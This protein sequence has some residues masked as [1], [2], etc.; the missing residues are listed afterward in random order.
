[1]AVFWPWLLHL[2]WLTGHVAAYG[3]ESCVVSAASLPTWPSPGVALASWSPG[4][5]AVCGCGVCL[6]LVAVSLTAG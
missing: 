6:G 5:L 3:S 1:M 2:G 4:S